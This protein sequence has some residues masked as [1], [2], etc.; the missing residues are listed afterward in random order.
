MGKKS[1]PSAPPPP[2]PFKTA[3]AQAGVNKEAAIT[4]AN[5]NRIDQ[6]TPQ[7]SITYTQTGTNADGT[8]KYA[9]HQQLSPDQMAIYNQQTG[10]SKALNG[11]AA[12][13]IDRVTQAQQTPF[14]FDKMNPLQS[15][16]SNGDQLQTS[17]DFSKL[18]PVVGQGDMSFSDIAKT[19][20]DT[21]YK[22]AAS[23]LDPQY[24]QLE[25]GE[26]NRLINSGISENSEAYRQAMDN[27]GRQ[28]TDAYNQ[29]NYSS[30]GAG[31]AAQQQEF[32][33]S[34]A[35]RQQGVN[36]L[37]MAGG[38]K[39]SALSQQFNTN[40]Q[41]ANQNNAIRQQQIDE[42]A[43]LRN[44]P[45]N[46][47]AALMGTSGGVSQPQ[48]NDFAQVGVAAPD[49]QGA[50]YANFNAANQ[51][52][53]A[54]QQARSQGLGG[55]FGLA[56]SLGSAAILSDMR[57]KHNLQR[58]GELASGIGTYLFSYLGSTKRHFG[59]VAQEVQKIIPEAVGQFKDGTL[60]VNHDKVWQA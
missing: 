52:Y 3:Q 55:I 15:A 11:L 22:Q 56:G 1:G 31:L 41:A 19:A 16:Q 50:V 46:D 9:Q 34:L 27:F 54:A 45:I 6:Y 58:V 18:K 7:G 10:I 53:Q 49:Y 26:R 39:N 12:G 4:Q 36:E 5:L 8:P 24:S 14:N 40:T 17:L 37:G 51:Q 35:G 57:I 32:D 28:R 21:V 44:L 2:D 23:R 38:F 33:Q 30:I 13:N 47:I 48:F 60:Y 42:A 20:A 59:F 43:Y 25:A 29:A